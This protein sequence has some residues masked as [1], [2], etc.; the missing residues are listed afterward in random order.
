MDYPKE[1]EVLLSIA[2][3]DLPME[4]KACC[5]FTVIKSTTQLIIPA[6]SITH[7]H[8]LLCVVQLRDRN[9]LKEG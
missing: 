6:R 7:E 8:D 2:R 9:L 1:R 4:I 5:L 3:K